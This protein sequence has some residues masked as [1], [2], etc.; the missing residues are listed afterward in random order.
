[1]DNRVYIAN[2]LETPIPNDEIAV[3][4]VGINSYRYMHAHDVISAL[5]NIFGYDKWSTTIVSLNIT[6]DALD[7]GINKVY[8]CYVVAHMKLTLY[9]HDNKEVYKEDIGVGSFMCNSMITCKEVAIKTAVSDGLKRCARLFGNRLGNQLYDKDNN[10][11][12]KDK[13]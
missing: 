3:R 9:T 2:L 1:M 8:S 13:A 5:N 10:N 7:N 12:N 4:Q 11:N 6:P